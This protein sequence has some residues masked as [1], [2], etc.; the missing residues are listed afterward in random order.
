MLTVLIVL[1]VL[2]FV[3]PVWGPRNWGYWGWSPVGLILLLIVL[4][5]LFGGHI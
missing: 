3:V 4:F 1:L 2:S 5:L